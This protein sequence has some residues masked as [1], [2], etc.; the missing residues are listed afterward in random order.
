MNIF[1][2]LDGTLLDSRERLFRLFTDLTGQT[3][4][5]FEDYWDLKRSMYDHSKILS[6]YLQYKE[7]NIL[8]FKQ[9]WLNLIE[10]EYYL[11]LDKPFLFSNTILSTL[12]KQGHKL[13]LI[14]ARQSK[15]MLLKQLKMHNLDKF[16]SEVLVTEAVRTKTQLIIESELGLS[17]SDLYVGDTGVD[18]QTAKQIG[19]RSMAVLSGFRNRTILQ[20]YKP[21]YIENDIQTVFKYV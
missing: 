18:I 6:T 4:L 16:F 11:L 14:T 1:F 9:E 20:S 3:L 21:D 10:T 7:E 5:E 12:E 19:V 2:D 15:V 13:Y 8:L 17:A